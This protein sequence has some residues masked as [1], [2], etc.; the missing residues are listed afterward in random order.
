MRIIEKKM[1]CILINFMLI[2]LP[3]LIINVALPEKYIKLELESRTNKRE[4]KMI[5]HWIF[6]GLCK[7][8]FDHSREIFSM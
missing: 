6:A 7:K 3:F 1:L 2:Q 5:M 8:C 4:K